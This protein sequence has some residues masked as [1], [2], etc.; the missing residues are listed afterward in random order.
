MD[1]PIVQ[2]FKFNKDHKNVVRY[3]SEAEDNQMPPSINNIYVEKWALGN[4]YP[5][6]IKIT[7]E[8]IS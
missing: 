8:D 4:P 3:D 6:K 7:I 2:T 1:E 5:K